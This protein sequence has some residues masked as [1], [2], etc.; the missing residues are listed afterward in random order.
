MKLIALFVLLTACGSSA[1]RPAT[2]SATEAVVESTLTAD[3]GV[4]ISYDV[5][6][7]GDTT[8][9]FVHCWS[10]DRS[11][12]KPQIDALAAD[13]RI[14]SMDLAGH[15]ASG[16]NRTEWTVARL[17]ADVQQVAE[18]VGVERAIVIGHSM[19]GP[20]ALDVARRMPGK[21]VGVVCADTLHDADRRPPEE[22]RAQVIKG[23]ET[24]FAGTMK[25]GMKFMFRED[26]DPAVRE[27]VQKRA[28]AANPDVAVPLMRE[29]W[30]LELGPMLAAA[31]VPIRCINA[32]PYGPSPAIT[33]VEA[34]RKYA[35]FDA[36]IME[37][38]GHFL[39]LERPDAFTAHLR[40]ILAQLATR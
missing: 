7:R 22:L 13:Y 8:L 35:D 5:R 30:T 40:D 20:V 36:V 32:A 38:V 4:S 33:N 28:L 16:S 21:V 12:W 1:P 37:G 25:M 3:D 19:G 18:K 6:G 34:N 24:D 31:K 17:G 15:G 26:A 11:F 27:R 23:F 9:V 10:C 2:P 14:L 39:Q 29:L